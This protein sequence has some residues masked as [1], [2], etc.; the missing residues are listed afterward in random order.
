[1]GVAGFKLSEEVVEAWD[2]NA[3]GRRKVERVEHHKDVL[4][5][6]ARQG[7]R[8]TG[9]AVEREVGRGGAF[10]KV[11]HRNQMGEREPRPPGF[12]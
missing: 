10:F 1:M 12:S 6:K 4:S 11:A 8:F 2:L 7:D 9:V 5:L 3:S